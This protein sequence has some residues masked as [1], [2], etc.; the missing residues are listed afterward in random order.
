MSEHDGILGELRGE[1]KR[2]FY[3]DPGTENVGLLVRMD[4]MEQ[5]LKRIESEQ[6]ERKRESAEEKQRRRGSSVAIIVVSIGAILS[7]FG[8]VLLRLWK[9]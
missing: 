8:N 5:L 7:F 9:P 3:G 4:R 2:I 6:I 1:F